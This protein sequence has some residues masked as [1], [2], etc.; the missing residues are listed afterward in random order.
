MRELEI[1][2]RRCTR[3]FVSILKTWTPEGARVSAN[4]RKSRILTSRNVFASERKREPP[5]RLLETQCLFLRPLA[6]D[7]GLRVSLPLASIK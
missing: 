5:S 1:F 4:V 3:D 6:L 7:T 2:V